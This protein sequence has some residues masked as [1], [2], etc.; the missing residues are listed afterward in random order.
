MFSDG[1]VS[2]LKYIALFL[3]YYTQYNFPVMNVSL[4]EFPFLFIETGA[5]HDKYNTYKILEL[6]C[7]R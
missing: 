3:T 5:C 4:M 1:R 2:R 6:L 7:Q